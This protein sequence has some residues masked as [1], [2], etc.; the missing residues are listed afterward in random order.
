LATR[1]LFVPHKTNDSWVEVVSVEF[2][3]YAGFSLAQKQRSIRS[4]HASAITA[5]IAA[6]P[7]EVSSKSESET[8]RALSA[9]NLKVLVPNG[10]AVPLECAFQ[11]AKLFARGGPYLDLLELTPRDAKRDQ[12]LRS[13]G[14]LLG[15]D[16]FGTRWPSEPKTAFYDWLYLNA[17]SKHSDLMSAAL[18]HDAFSDIEFNPE[19]SL[20]CQAHSLALFAALMQ[21]NLVSPVLKSQQDFLNLLTLR[22]E[23]MR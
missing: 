7:L 11:S 19:K 8:G 2:Q 15:F 17:I 6:N 20:N 23:S 16:W 9:F 1:P 21:E 3:W 13:N 4:L 22:R 14:P 5:G 18:R 10:A 12:R